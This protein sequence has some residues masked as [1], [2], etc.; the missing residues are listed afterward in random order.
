LLVGCDNK[1]Q[2]TETEIL[3]EEVEDL[4]QQIEILKEESQ[5]SEPKHKPFFYDE[6]K[7]LNN[8]TNTEDFEFSNYWRQQAYEVVIKYM[9][10]RIKKDNPNCEIVRRGYYNPN[11]VQYI[12]SQGFLIKLY[13]EFDCNQNYINPS[14][15]WVEAFYV[16]NSKW[17]LE[18]VD[19]KLTH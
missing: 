16:G 1:P 2:Q 8:N 14:Y 12:G 19:Q 13:C 3:K 18:L 17:N 11:L 5:T 15:F 10:Q 7:Q 9:N 6:I 4:K